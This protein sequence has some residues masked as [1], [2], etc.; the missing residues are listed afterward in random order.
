MNWK[1]VKKGYWIIASVVI[2]LTIIRLLLPSIVKSY[3]NGKLNDLP[4]YTGHV[5]DIDIYLIRGGLNILIYLWNGRR[6]SRGDLLE[7]SLWINRQCIS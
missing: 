4:G 7:R 6:Y 2:I 1:D 3:I 5:D